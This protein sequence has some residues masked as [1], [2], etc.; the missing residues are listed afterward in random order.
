MS[1]VGPGCE[2]AAAENKVIKQLLEKSRANK[3]KNDKAILE[4]YW[5]RGYK[6]FFSYGYN[7]DLV[8]DDDGKWRLQ[9]PNDLRSRIERKIIETIRGGRR[10]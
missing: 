9:E 5:A 2:A 10:E 3:E 8:K 4:E 1:G 6:P 7:K